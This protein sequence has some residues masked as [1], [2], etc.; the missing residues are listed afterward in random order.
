MQRNPMRI[1]LVIV[2]CI[3]GGSCSDNLQS[4]KSASTSNQ[5]NTAAKSAA[6]EQY[7][8]FRSD[9]VGSDSAKDIRVQSTTDGGLKMTML[10]TGNMPASMALGGGGLRYFPDA[11]GSTNVAVMIDSAVGHTE[12]VG[13]RF[14]RET[15]IN[16][17]NDGRVET[18]RAGIEA[19]DG[20]GNR[21]ISRPTKPYLMVKKR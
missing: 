1:A 16:V 15:T 18:D 8:V 13:L 12:I 14:T 5:Q 4:P 17:L 6:A 3:F 21:W 2:G 11:P 7:Y 9:Y 20:G 19:S 10:P